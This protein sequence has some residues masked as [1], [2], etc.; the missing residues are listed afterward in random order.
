MIRDP[1]KE[2]K[3]TSKLHAENLDGMSGEKDLKKS[4]I[5]VLDTEISENNNQSEVE[6]VTPKKKHKKTKRKQ[7]ALE[8]GSKQPKKIKNIQDSPAT[9]SELPVAVHC[10]KESLK[11]VA[12]S[13]EQK[14]KQSV[15]GRSGGDKDSLMGRL[16]S[17]SSYVKGVLSLLHIPKHK[18]SSN[19]ESDDDGG[20]IKA[21]LLN[22]YLRKGFR[23][24]H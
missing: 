11:I 21:F 15:P 7:E 3:K 5:E 23:I 16:G 1:L 2:I 6:C 14:E 4:R 8:D 10:G 13:K 22:N 20:K 12:K 18:Q 19:A 9:E 24:A 17:E